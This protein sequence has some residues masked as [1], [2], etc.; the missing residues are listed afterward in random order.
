MPKYAFVYKPNG[1]AGEQMFAIHKCDCKDL[2]RERRILDN[3]VV[4]V[5]GES[6]EE[7]AISEL[8]D[9]YGWDRAEAYDNL[10]EVRIYP[11]VGAEK[12]LK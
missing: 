4:E 8:M 3:T 10:S 7:V 2:G 1:K 9:S 12:K 5:E 11:C 6:P